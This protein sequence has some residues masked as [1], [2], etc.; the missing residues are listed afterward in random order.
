MDCV[1]NWAAG[2]VEGDT[3]RALAHAE[4]TQTKPELPR[5][6][7]VPVYDETLAIRV[8]DVAGRSHYFLVEAPKERG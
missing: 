2:Y 8:G 1:D 7:R 4:R 3:F 5:E 6:L